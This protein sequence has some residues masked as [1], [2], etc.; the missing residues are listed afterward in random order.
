VARLVTDVYNLFRRTHPA[1][2][3]TQEGAKLDI[4]I[5]GFGMGATGEVLSLG[6]EGMLVAVE[7]GRCAILPT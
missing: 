7:G 4:F 6:E 2:R 3:A 5:A 1:P